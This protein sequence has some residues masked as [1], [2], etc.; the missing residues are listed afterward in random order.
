MFAFFTYK[1]KSI[2]VHY[3]VRNGFEIRVPIIIVYVLY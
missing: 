1:L 3:I 2:I